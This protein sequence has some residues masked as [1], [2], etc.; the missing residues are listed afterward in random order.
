[1]LDSRFIFQYLAKSVL[2]IN[3]MCYVQQ[4]YTLA[5]Q[6]GQHILTR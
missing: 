1:M 2:I 4:I 6:W 3:H 5:K